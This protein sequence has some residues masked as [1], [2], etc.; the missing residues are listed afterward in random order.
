MRRTS[1]LIATLAFLTTAAAMAADVV[2]VK[3]DAGVCTNPV[4]SPD[5]KSIAYVCTAPGAQPSVSIA[6]AAGGAWK[7][8]VLVKDADS[9]VWS[10]D[11]KQIAC[12]SGGMMIA[13]VAT[14]A[15]K[16]LSTDVPDKVCSPTA[17][18]PTGSYILYTETGI[19]GPQGFVWDLKTGRPIG[20]SVGSGKGAWTNAGKLITWQCG[21]DVGSTWVKLVDVALRASRAIVPGSCAAGAFVPKGD[22]FAYLWLMPSAARGE[23]IYK[24]GL[25]SGLPA[26]CVAIRSEEIAWSRDGAQFAAVSKLIPKKGAEPEMNLYIGN[27]KN[28]YF[29][30]V[31]KGI[32]SPAQVGSA[33]S[34][35]PDGKSVAAA[36]ADGGIKIVKL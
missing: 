14:G 27:T 22:A 25:K 10:P 29:K 2:I 28:W 1:L 13:T 8:R 15:V 32:A 7:S 17:W 35:S 21:A 5:G 16:R 4:W 18:S 20:T 36:T 6:T 23:G 34:W 12:H 11:S 9:P 26:K 24:V 3:P 30:V 19:A 31:S 33:I